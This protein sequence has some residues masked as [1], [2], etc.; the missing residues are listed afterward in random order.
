[1]T[2]RELKRMLAAADPAVRARLDHLDFAAM[3]ADLLADAEAGLP[4]LPES[5]GSTEPA[6]APPRRRLVLAVGATALAV[7]V[8]LVLVLAGG[9]SDRSSRAYGAELIRFAESTPLLLLEGP[10]WRV[11]NVNESKTREATNGSMEFVTGKPVPLPNVRPTGFSKSG[12]ARVTGLQ[13]ASVRQRLVSLRWQPEVLMVKGHRVRYFPHLEGPHITKLP[14]LGTTATVDTRAERYANQG[15]PGDREM[16]AVWKEDGNVLELQASVPNLAGLEE[17]LGWLAKVDSQTW[18]EAMPAKVV[19]SANIE[20]TVREM[21]K[22]IPL[23]KTFAISRVPDE[24]L[25]TSRERVASEVTGTV[26]CLWLRQWGEARRGGD[27]AAEAEAE[28]AMAS[29]QS[30]PIVREEGGDSYP[31]SEIHEVAQAMPRGYWIYRGHPQNLL[32]HAESIGCARAGLPLLP[33]KM[34]RQREGGVPPPPD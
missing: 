3:E 8:A 6:P 19:K 25:T 2:A 28:K 11:Q 15:G 30:W 7:I 29:S 12:K 20:G 32:A 17:R 10:N 22:G 13:P 9:G 1:M 27:E 21:L 18:L 34:K 23:P 31:A 24:G 26:A 4:P 14:V 16:I 33:E 5:A